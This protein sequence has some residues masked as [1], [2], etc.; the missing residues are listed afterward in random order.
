MLWFEL[1]N[2]RP[3][4]QYCQVALLGA[5]WSLLSKN[6]SATLKTGPNTKIVLKM[7]LESVL[8]IELIE[9]RIKTRRRGDIWSSPQMKQSTENIIGA[10]SIRELGWLSLV[11]GWF[12]NK[13][14]LRPLH[15]PRNRDRE[16]YGFSRARK[17]VNKSSTC[18][19]SVATCNDWCIFC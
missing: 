1:S 8:F 6:S 16:E 2:L 7:I 15:S 17:T 5:K 19:I 13:R 11:D 14:G 18:V 12:R 9:L 3:H 10:L 4:D